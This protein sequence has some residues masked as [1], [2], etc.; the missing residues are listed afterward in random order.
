MIRAYSIKIGDLILSK[1]DSGF[2]PNRLFLVESL[3]K[4]ENYRSVI[5][6]EIVSKEKHYTNYLPDQILNFERLASL[7]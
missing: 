6:R 5:I 3:V 2:D 1:R 4:Y 7:D